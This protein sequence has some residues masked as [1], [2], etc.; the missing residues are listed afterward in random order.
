MFLQYIFEGNYI[1]DIVIAPNHQRQG[2]GKILLNH[3]IFQMKKLNSDMIIRLR[4][5]KS[6]IKAYNF[7]FK[8][9]FNEISCFAEHTCE[10]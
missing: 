2:Y 1:T 10:N 7:Y 4:V 9:G 3:C 8:N 5:A 6:N